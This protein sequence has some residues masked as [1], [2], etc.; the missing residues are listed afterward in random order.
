M[1]VD[2]GASE[3][4]IPEYRLPGY[5][6]IPTTASKDGL[7]YTAANGKKIPNLGE[8]QAVVRTGD[9]SIKCIRFQVCDVTKIL[10]SVSRIVQAGHRV[11][12]DSPDIGSFIECKSTGQR[13][14]LRQE[15][16]V[17]MLDVWVKPNENPFHR[18]GM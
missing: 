7:E 4:V 17:Y 6:L 12:F 9:G 2:S 8:K 15:Q 10:A 16:G 18:L 14:Y 13:T 11:I 3:T 1:I 5:P